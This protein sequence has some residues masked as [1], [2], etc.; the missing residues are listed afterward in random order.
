MSLEDLP[1]MLAKNLQLT[2][3]LLSQ[4]YA[5][6]I[7]S[8]GNKYFL[9]E[10][11]ESKEEREEIL[12]EIPTSLVTYLDHL[13]EHTAQ[14]HQ[15]VANKMAIPNDIISHYLDRGFSRESRV[16]SIEEVT[17]LLYN[18]RAVEIDGHVAAIK[19]ETSGELEGWDHKL[20]FNHVL[21]VYRLIYGSDIRV[22]DVRRIFE[23]HFEELGIEYVLDESAGRV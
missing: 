23:G 12:R 11:K 4:D 18:E 1:A 20:I 7:A 22:A 13:K 5:N 16:M 15:D 2:E 3:L 14:Y 9:S 17:N 10:M 6:C 8:V 21:E 19:A